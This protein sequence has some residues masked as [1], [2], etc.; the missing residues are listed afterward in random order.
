MYR[1]LRK[2]KF[3]LGDYSI[4]CIQQKDIMFI[5]DWRNLQTNVLRQN[6]HISEE[7]QLNYFKNEI[8]PSFDEKEPKQ[9]LM[10]FFHKNNLVGYGGV[11][12]ISWQDK[13]GE[14]SFLTNPSRHQ[15]TIYEEDFTAFIFLIKQLAFEDIEFNRIHG[16]TFAFR[17]F[18]IAI[19]ENN[20]FVREGIMKRHV[21]INNKYIDSIIHGCNKCIYSDE[22]LTFGEALFNN[23]LIT[24]ISSKTPMISALISAANRISK[25]I[26]VY[27]GDVKSECVG[28]YFVDYYWEMPKLVD[29]SV[30]DILEYCRSNSI[31]SIIPS[32]DGEL[33]YFANIKS[34]LFEHGISVMI[35]DKKTIE[36]C[37]DK[38][39]FFI[40]LSRKGFNI[41]PTF[42][43]PADNDVDRWVVKERYGAGSSSLAINISRSEALSFASRMQSPIFQ[44]FVKGK[45][46]SV[47]V[48]VSKSGQTLGIVCR[49]RELVINGESKITCTKDNKK[50]EKLICGILKCLSFYGHVIFQIIEDGDGELHIIE[51]NPRFGGASTLSLAAGLDSFYWF[52]RESQGLNVDSYTFSIT[53]KK[54]IRYS[55]DLVINI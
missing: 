22:V 50:I 24:S 42:L 43:E 53:D 37:L 7:Q 51:C 20:G 3:T 11:V 23:I 48:Y 41:I 10:S 39:S 4:C 47:D 8:L 34:Q 9:I 2:Q 46:Y 33:Q 26:K 40:E 1:C 35:S 52:L 49:T 5:R 6:E 27:G 13:R 29:M 12:H 31:S 54:Q 30:N 15:N 18:H 32:R 36:I 19:M 28:K 14:L 45:E 55:K 16:E 17:D 44:P 21:R 25:D 38:F